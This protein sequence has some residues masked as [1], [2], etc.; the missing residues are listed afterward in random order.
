MI[1]FLFLVEHIPAGHLIRRVH[2]VQLYL[3]I[4][5]NIIMFI[6]LVHLLELLLLVFSIGKRHLILYILFLNFIRTIW[7]HHDRRLFVKR[8]TTVVKQ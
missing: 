4:Y 8:T 1:W 6:G 3:L 2:L 5:G 7:A